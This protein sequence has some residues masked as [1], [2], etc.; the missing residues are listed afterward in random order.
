MN[1]STGYVYYTCARGRVRKHPLTPYLIGDSAIRRA[2]GF[3]Q[4]MWHFASY[5]QPSLIME[6]PVLLDR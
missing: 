4:L 3:I 1:I 5:A 2:R 6:R